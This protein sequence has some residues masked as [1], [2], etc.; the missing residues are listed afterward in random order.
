MGTS[1]LSMGSDTRL[2]RH[3]Y[4]KKSG[5]V[6]QGL[7]QE[8]L[9]KSAASLG[10]RFEQECGLVCSD[11]GSREAMYECASLLACQTQQ[12]SA[13]RGEGSVKCGWRRERQ[14]LKR[15]GRLY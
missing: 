14:W 8:H 10:G 2:R 12:V 11:S 9:A 7:S 3:D 5:L 6:G 4:E 15:T 13:S 1:A